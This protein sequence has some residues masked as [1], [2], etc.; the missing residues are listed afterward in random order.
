M[1]VLNG[2]LLLALC[3]GW[4]DKLWYAWFLVLTLIACV[5]TGLLSAEMPAGLNSHGFTAV[6][7]PLLQSQMNPAPYSAILWHFQNRQCPVAPSAPRAR[8]SVAAADELASWPL[9]QVLH[10]KHHRGEQGE[11]T[12][13]WSW[14]TYKGCSQQLVIQFI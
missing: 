5:M 6:L 2:L 10:P 3:Y 1:L 7:P 9:Q 14:W 8:R 13:I 11:S 12:L 4:N